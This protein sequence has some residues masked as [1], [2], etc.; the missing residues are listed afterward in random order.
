M[1]IPE[2]QSAHPPTEDPDSEMQLDLAPTTQKDPPADNEEVGTVVMS[3]ETARRLE[4]EPDQDSG[5]RPTASSSSFRLFM[6]MVAALDLECDQIDINNAFTEAVLK[7]DI[8]LRVP[9]GLPNV[10]EGCVLKLRKSLYGLKQ[11]AHDW[12]ETISE[13]LISL[14]FKWLESDP[15]LF[16]HHERG[17]HLLLY[18]GDMPCAAKDSSQIEWFKSKP[19]FHFGISQTRRR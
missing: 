12:Y 6:A 19:R 7:E 1:T 11:A 4:E 17:I 16:R 13:Y 5:K 8:Y 9:E 14:G 10:L 18:V 2:E 3:E 15:C